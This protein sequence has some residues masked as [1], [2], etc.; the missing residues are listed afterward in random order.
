ME[1]V[2]QKRRQHR[3]AVPDGRIRGLRERAGRQ[4]GRPGSGPC[5]LQPE[6]V[7]GP[8][9]RVGDDGLRLEVQVERVDRE[10]A[11]EAGLLVPAERD[12]REGR[13]RHV[14]ADRP[15]T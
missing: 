2:A 1:L 13:V 11:A 4:D 9:T 5:R 10:L 6:R 3:D 8:R 14:D 7:R 12:A 15:R